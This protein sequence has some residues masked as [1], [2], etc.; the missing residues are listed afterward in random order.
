ML[1]DLTELDRAFSA[2]SDPVRRGM[3]ARLSRGPASVSDLA[4]PLPISLPAVLQ[5]LKSLEASGL[6]ASE[7]KGRVRTVRLQTGTL[8]AAETWLTRHREEWEARVDRFEQHL[9]TIKQE[10]AK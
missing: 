10:D 3:L 4:R 6:V 1:N 2:L 7:K 5:H 8:A 9:H